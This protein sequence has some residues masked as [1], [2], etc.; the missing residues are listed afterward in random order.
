[1]KSASAERGKV[2]GIFLR[3]K[4]N[5]NKKLTENN[6]NKATLHVLGTNDTNK[7]TEKMPVSLSENVAMISYVPNVNEVY[8]KWIN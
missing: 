1:M 2:I 7:Q 6:N 8:R 3:S 5:K 4:K